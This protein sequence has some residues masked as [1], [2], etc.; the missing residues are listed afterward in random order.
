MIEDWLFVSQ[1]MNSF[2]VDS[3]QS[4]IWTFDYTK[5]YSR[6]GYWNGWFIDDANYGI[7]GW[8]ETHFYIWK[9][10]CNRWC[11][12]LHGICVRYH[13]SLPNPRHFVKL[14]TNQN[15]SQANL[16]RI[17]YLLYCIIFYRFHFQSY[18]VVQTGLFGHY[19]F[20]FSP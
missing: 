5:Y 19:F 9:C 3:F 15:W 1:S 12:F 6:A 16:K 4:N 13:T 20:H 10:I 17:A 2:F 18:I 11:C 8:P 7:S 14:C